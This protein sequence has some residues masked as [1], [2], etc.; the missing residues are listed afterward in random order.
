[1]TKTNMKNKIKHK[2]NLVPK[3]YKTICGNNRLWK[4]CENCNRMTRKIHKRK[5][6]F[7]CW[8]CYVKTIHK[9][10]QISPK[11]AIEGYH[12]DFEGN[13]K[14]KPY[15]EVYQPNWGWSYL[16]KA[17]YQIEKERKGEKLCYWIIKKK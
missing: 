8:K 11:L 5:N 4:K 17:H 7:L 6:T 1:M 14:S 3:G 12:C 16:C 2:S 15:C 10:P 9:M 13:C